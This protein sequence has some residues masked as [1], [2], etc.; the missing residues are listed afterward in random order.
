MDIDIDQDGE[1]SGNY[2]PGMPD[3]REMIVPDENIPGVPGA[4]Q[5]M[6]FPD[7]DITG[8]LISEVE[9]ASTKLN[10]YKCYRPRSMQ[11]SLIYWRPPGN[12]LKPLVQEGTTDPWFD[13]SANAGLDKKLNTLAHTV[14]IQYGINKGLNIF[15]ERRYQVF[16]KEVAQIQNQEVI[17]KI[18]PKNRIHGRRAEALKHIMFLKDNRDDTAKERGCA[19]GDKTLHHI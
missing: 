12:N 19:D 10:I 14:L 17:I 3:E 16:N 4:E 13:F 1:T 9:E 6:G 8:V 15:G 2:N 18:N 7:E 5:E 11:Y